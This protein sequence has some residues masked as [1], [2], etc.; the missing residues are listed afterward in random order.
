MSY[1]KSKKLIKSFC[2]SVLITVLFSGYLSAEE[3][4]TGSIAA[5]RAAEQKAAI[6]KRAEQRKQELAAKKMSDAQKGATNTE[7]KMVEEQ[8]AS[9]IGH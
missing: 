8:K 4:E 1:F 7:Q 2:L 5:K 6:A 9:P 3:Y